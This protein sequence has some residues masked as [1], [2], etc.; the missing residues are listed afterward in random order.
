MEEQPRRQGASR[1]V[2]GEVVGRVL[3]E[4]SRRAVSRPAV[5]AAH[6]GLVRVLDE[7]IDAARA[8]ARAAERG[9]VGPDHIAAALGGDRE[10]AAAVR[11]RPPGRAAG[12]AHEFRSLVRTRTGTVGGGLPFDSAALRLLSV[13]LAGLT[14]RTA[15]LAAGVAR[16]GGSPTIG[17]AEIDAALGLGLPGG[18]GRRARERARHA[19]ERETAVQEL[20]HFGEP[21]VAPTPVWGSLTDREMLDRIP[22]VA[23][24]ADQGE[25]NL[26]SWVR[27]LRR[28]KVTWAAIGHA[29]GTSRQAAWERFSWEE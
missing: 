23:V 13:T 9:K 29:L 21:S 6:A 20:L 17:Y 1:R 7:L 8:T 5:V 24:A 14:L 25:A 12:A 27:E 10:L 4:R 22:G 18:L 3:K 26:R 19:V 28:R 2:R 15:T 16:E 11:G